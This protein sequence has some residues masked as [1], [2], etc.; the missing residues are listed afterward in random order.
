MPTPIEYG[1]LL[2]A[3]MLGTSRQTILNEIKGGK[4]AVLGK[5]RKYRITAASL[6][7]Y[8]GIS[9]QRMHD[10]I[11]SSEDSACLSRYSGYHK[12]RPRGSKKKT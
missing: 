4:L 7:R 9:Q 10:A 8:L 3:E 1:T 11:A 5:P 2:V 6:A 12:G